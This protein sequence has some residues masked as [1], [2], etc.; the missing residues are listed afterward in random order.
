MFDDWLVGVSSVPDKKFRDMAIGET[1]ISNIPLSIY[2]A[3]FSVACQAN[4]APIAKPRPQTRDTGTFT[5]APTPAPEPEPAPEPC[6]TPESSPAPSPEPQPFRLSDLQSAAVRVP[7]SWLSYVQCVL[8]RGRR[9]GSWDVRLTACGTPCFLH[10]FGCVH[11][12]SYVPSVEYAEREHKPINKRQFAAMMMQVYEEKITTD[13][14][15]G[16]VSAFPEFVVKYMQMHYGT[17]SLVVA[18][19]AGYARASCVHG[20]VVFPT[21]TSAAHP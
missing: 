5:L 14:T 15:E 20:V 6:A 18:R 16:R 1:A 19:L 12:Y 10:C 8:K 2:Q 9:H 21:R 13:A 11:H 4:L 7:S 3:A 17:R